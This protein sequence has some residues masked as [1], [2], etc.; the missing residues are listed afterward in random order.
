[1]VSV[2]FLALGLPASADDSCGMDRINMYTFHVTIEADR[3][4][5]RI[6]DVAKINVT[7][8]RPA[9]QD[10]GGNGIPTPRPTSAPAE[11]AAAGASAWV[12]RVYFYAFG[13]NTDADGKSTI[14][15]TIP[16]YARPGWVFVAVVAE[17]YV[18]TIACWDIW[19]VG[20]AEDPRMFKIKD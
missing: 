14:P 1:M 11:G 6:G 13:P 12:K 2:A 4:A 9:D 10:P 17:K 3:K 16:R 19:E 18:T 20:Y 5:Y 15:L 7:V 8:T